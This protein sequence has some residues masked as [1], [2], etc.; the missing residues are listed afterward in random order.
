MPSK[1]QLRE[2][3]RALAHDL[4]RIESDIAKLVS[5]I[6][7][8][9]AGIE[10]RREDREEAKDKERRD[11]LHEAIQEKVALRKEKKARLG[12]RKDRADTVTAKLER[13]VERIKAKGG[14]PKVISLLLSFRPMSPQGAIIGVTG[15]YTAGPVDDDDEDAI[16]LWKQYHASHLAQGWSGLGYQ[17]GFTRQGTI[18]LLRPF[19]SVGSH[20]LGANT[21]RIGVSVH[22][23]TGD[24]WTKPQR[25][26]YAWWLNNGHTSTFPA[27]HRLPRSARDLEIRV[28][29]DFGAT[30]CPG[31]FESGYKN[32]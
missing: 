2:E 21:G 8:I 16:R 4:N 30:A 7:R 5:E 32:P 6:E 31:S 29:N 26:A 1:D 15:H 10:G 23:T 11:E 22:G 18:V 25:Q 13:V 3:R 24:T 17:I 12:S 19:T 28:H 14:K 9:D 27:S 20:T